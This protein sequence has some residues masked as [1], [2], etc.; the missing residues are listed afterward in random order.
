M[1]LLTQIVLIITSLS[2]IGYDLY[3]WY[4]GDT[5]ATI[6]QVVLDFTSMWPVASFALGMLFGHLLW[7]IVK[8]NNSFFGLPTYVWVALISV[9]LVFCLTYP[10]DYKLMDNIVGWFKLYPVI[11]FV[12]G[13]PFGR[14]IFPQPT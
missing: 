6:S 11:P 4:K 12:L 2:L 5:T 1:R 7:P 3:V 10:A 13:L 14:I 8:P 9:F